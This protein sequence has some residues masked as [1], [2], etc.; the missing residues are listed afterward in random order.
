MSNKNVQLVSATLLQNELKSDV[1]RFT[2]LPSFKPVNNPICSKVG[3]MWGVKRATSLCKSFCSNVAKQV[4]R[5]C[6]PFY[7]PFYGTFKSYPR[8]RYFWEFLMGVCR[9][10]L[11]ILTLFQT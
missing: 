6:C 3:L 11:R 5:F 9:L 2:Q 1:A 8:G 10:V 7:R 4:A